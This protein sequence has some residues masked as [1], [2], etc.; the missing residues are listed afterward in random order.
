MLS[1]VLA[2]ALSQ[3]EP[4]P[5]ARVIP[6]PA[7]TVAG[8]TVLQRGL[9]GTGAGVLGA[10]ASLGIAMLLVGQNGKFDPVFA[11]AALSS[12]LITGGAFVVHEAFGGRGEITIAFLG[13]A[14]AIAGAA[15]IAI[16]ADPSRSLTPYILSAV[17]AVPASVL[18][19]VALE[20]TSPK[21]RATAP[22]VA[23]AFNG[24]YGTF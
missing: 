3:A 21:A 6:E 19:V 4:P 8:P 24:V 5:E 13:A 15:G 7:A 11:V 10:G 22:R 14:L 17:A 2:L 18:A 16:A 12:L 23:L 9:L 1:L 20:G